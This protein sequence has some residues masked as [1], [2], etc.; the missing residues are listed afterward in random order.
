MAQ[1]AIGPG[2]AV[3]SRHRAVL[4]SDDRPMTVKTA[5]MLINQ[6]LDSFLARE[7]ADYDAWTRFAIG[8]LEDRGH[9]TG[10]YGR[11]EV[12]AT[13]KA[14]AVQG[15]VEAGILEARGGKVRLLRREELADGWD[16]ASDARATVWEATQHLIRRMETKG[17]AAAA[18]LLA[19]LGPR[20]E[21]AKELA[22]RLY[23]VCERKGW[24][25]E[26]VDYNGL[27]LAW[28]ELTRLAQSVD[29]SPAQREMAV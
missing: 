25:Q 1:A 21:A 23:Q 22:Y 15:V 9:E 13:A 27:V 10:E 16:P 12:L 7:D 3:F 20:A 24:A 6:E 19:R 17:E 29:T 4:E 2:M 28:P 26:A 8:W 5:L 11:A 14:V 18:D